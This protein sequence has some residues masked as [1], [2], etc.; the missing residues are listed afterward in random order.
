MA[1]DSE[2]LL[3]EKRG[4]V[5]WV[6]MNRPDKLNALDKTLVR[7][8]RAYFEAKYDDDETRLV[9]L[10][11]AGR[12]FCAGLDLNDIGTDGSVAAALKQQTNIR[13]IQ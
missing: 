6:T 13:D 3:V 8:L 7:E 1:Q 11:G 2:V 12:A 4:A 9:V 10:R 5:E